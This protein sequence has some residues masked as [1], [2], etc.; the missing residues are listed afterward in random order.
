VRGLF[1]ELPLPEGGTHRVTGPAVKLSATPGRV[2]GAAP[3]PGEHTKEVLANL[4]GLNAAAIG[5]LA[6][7]GVIALTAVLPH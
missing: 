6:A 2:E 7:R 5:N 3:S 1:P 4:L